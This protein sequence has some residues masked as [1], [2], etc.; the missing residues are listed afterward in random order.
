M[1]TTIPSG[2]EGRTDL[3]PTLEVRAD[4]RAVMRPDAASV[5][6]GVGVGARQVSGRVAPEV[7]AAA[8]GEAKALAAVDMGV[9]RDGDASST[10]LDFLGATPD[11]DVHLVVYSPGASEGLSEEQKVNRQRFADLCKRLLDGFVADR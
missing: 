9:P 11:Q 6:R 2:W 5:E 7:V 3:G 1:L 10:L 4:G 8:V